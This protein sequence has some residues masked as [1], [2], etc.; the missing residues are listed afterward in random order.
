MFANILY[1]LVSIAVT[2]V[3]GGYHLAS[4]EGLFSAAVALRNGSETFLEYATK[5]QA[6]FCPEQLICSKT[7]D[8]TRSDVLNTLPEALETGSETIRIEDIPKIVGACCLPC[9]C[10]EATCQENG[11]CCLSKV[12]LD[13]VGENW[14]ADANKNMSADF[15]LLN[16]DYSEPEDNET[17]RYTA[18]AS[19]LPE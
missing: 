3:S 19:K 2:S 9:S 12:Y 7:G 17:N 6:M 5:I 13:A 15:S 11:N 8:M 1:I 14:D 4:Y 18:N 10:D 16:D